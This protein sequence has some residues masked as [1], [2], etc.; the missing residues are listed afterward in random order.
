MLNVTNVNEGPTSSS[1]AGE[2]VIA[3][4]LASTE[5]P[6]DIDP[7]V[8]PEGDPLTY[9]V[10]QLPGTGTVLLNGTAIT[11]GQV[12]SQAQLQA[13]VYTV[14]EVDGNGPGAQTLTLGFMVT[15]GITAPQ[16][17]N[18]DL[19]VTDAVNST[20]IGDGAANRLDGAAANDSLSGLGGADILI[21]SIGD[22]LLDGGTGINSLL[23]GTGND[24]YV[25]DVTGDSIIDTGG[26]DT[27]IAT[28]SFALEAGNSIETLR[29][30]GAATFG[31]INLT[32]NEIANFIQ[33]NA[34]ANVIDGGGGGDV[35][36]GH[37]GNDTYHVD[38]EVNDYVIEVA[39]E[40]NDVVIASVSYAILAGQS[41]ELLRTNNAAA[42]AALSFFGNE[43]ANEL[44]GN[45]GVNTLNG[46]GG[47]DIMTGFGGNDT[48]VV[49]NLND[50]AFEVAGGGLDNVM[51][52]INYVLQA[53]THIEQMRTVDEFATTAINLTG[54]EF[55]NRLKG[56]AGAN[57]LNGGASVDIM[58]GLAGNDTYHVNHAL[59][60]LIEI[61][62]QG[63]D[64]VI[65]S[66][67][68][69]LQAGV[70][71]ELLRTVNP[72]AT[73]AI[74]L[75]GNQLANKL[76]GNAGAN[77]LNGRGGNDT[78]TGNA[79]NDKFV[80]NTGLNAATN[81]DTIIGYSVANDVIHLDNAVFTK[82]AN[83]ALVAGAFK[84]GSAATDIDDR[85][86]YN[87]ATGALSYDTNGSIAG[88]NTL[89]AKLD[90]GLALTN[91]E[92]LVI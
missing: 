36:Q 89:F 1:V 41:V 18:V 68:Y 57:A 7:A 62:G 28:T 5:F 61:A 29:T 83:G 17:F 16:V 37:G 59:D 65:T 20:L 10:S 6:L 50:K 77:T 14:A 2:E 33:G 91:A 24:T 69:T 49:D 67:S 39:N 8:D 58:E 21:G 11:L 79:G 78:M 31:A 32:G 72:G 70:S 80:F 45:A 76:Q 9:T 81:V 82:L 63:N 56:N 3:M 44:Q 4:E 92:F 46:N 48:Y 51:S 12:L 53:G 55:A 23:G 74:N 85:I 13:L 30:A 34:S 27:V 43:L 42:S 60:N 52:S 71:I 26:N 54:N 15:D 75:T 64:N 35:M 22:D 88:G 87:S 90:K 40:G 19:E 25:V 84:I 38:D 86:I 73:T 47:I 66:V